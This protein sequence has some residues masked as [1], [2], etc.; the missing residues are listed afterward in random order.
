[1]A[2]EASFE[3][4]LDNY[5]KQYNRYTHYKVQYNIRLV[6]LFRSVSMPLSLHGRCFRSVKKSRYRNKE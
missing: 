2:A 3:K 4:T 1:M 5:N 6:Y